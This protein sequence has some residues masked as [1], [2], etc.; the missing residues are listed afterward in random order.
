MAVVPITSWLRLVVIFA[1]VALLSFLCF[2]RLNAS[3]RSGHDYDVYQHIFHQKLCSPKT[4]PII[5]PEDSLPNCTSSKRFREAVTELSLA[6][7]CM[8]EYNLTLS[9]EPTMGRL[10]LF[11]ANMMSCWWI[12]NDS[13]YSWLI[14]RTVMLDRWGVELMCSILEPHFDVLEYGSGGSTTFF[15]CFF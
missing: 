10:Q 15:R 5:R 12:H 9:F 2:Q 6:E 13:L 14:A 11:P 8:F 4:A 3:V 1:A 7:M